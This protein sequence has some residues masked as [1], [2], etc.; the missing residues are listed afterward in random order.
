MDQYFSFL[1]YSELINQIED[2]AQKVK[3]YEDETT[4]FMEAYRDQMHES[5]G[6]DKPNYSDLKE[7]DEAWVQRI[8][9]GK[10]IKGKLIDFEKLHSIKDR[11]VG[12]KL[13]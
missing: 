6:G 10:M 7:D 1:E 12:E 3:F 9:K 13:T 8:I 5:A 11:K 4:V 2:L